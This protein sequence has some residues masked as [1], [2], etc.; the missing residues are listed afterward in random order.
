MA[1]K[2]S[3]SVTISHLIDIL[4]I[5]RYYM[6]QSSTSAA[7]TKPTTNPP[8]IGKNLIPYPYYNISNTRTSNGVTLTV[9]DDG[10]LT[11][12]GT[13][14][15]GHAYFTITSK[16]RL[17]AGN[18]YTLSG[19]PSGKS[20]ST[21]CL[22]I[23]SVAYDQS[24]S[25]TASFTLA[26]EKEGSLLSV[27]L[28]VYAGTTVNNLVF[29]PQVEIGNVA[30]EYEKP[31]SPNWVVTEPA[32]TAG[33]TNTLYF[34][35]VTTF[36]N[37]TFKCS[38]VS[39]S[40]SYEAAKEAYNKAASVESRVINA[41]T[42]I[43]SNKDAISLR[44]T[45]TE[46][47]NSRNG[48]LLQNG[49]GEYCDNTNYSGQYTRG[50][51]P[52]GA[53]G[54]FTQGGIFQEYI[55]FNK[56]VTYDYE[57]YVRRQPSAAASTTGYFSLI[58]YDVDKNIIFYRYVLTSNKNLF[59]LSQSLNPGDTVAHFT[60]LSE[61]KTDGT[62]NKNFLI[63]GYSDSTGYVYPD[64][65]YSRYCHYNIYSDPSS[66]N[67]TDNTITLSQPWTGSAYSAGTC[68]GQSYDGDT[69]IYLGDRSNHATEWTRQAG[70][71]DAGVVTPNWRMSHERLE[72]ARYIRIGFNVGASN[73]INYSKIY[74]GIHTVDQDARK[75]LDA[76]VGDLQQIKQK[77]T[78]YVDKDE[79]N[80]YRESTESRFD[81][82]SDNIAMN[83]SKTMEMI[84]SVDGDLKSRFNKLSKYI[85][86]SVDGIEIGDETNKLKLILDNDAIRFV[87]GSSTIGWWDGENFHTGNIMVRTRE[88]AQ[89]GQFAYVPRSDGSLMFLKVGPALG[90]P[91]YVNFKNADFFSYSTTPLGSTDGVIVKNEKSASMTI[92]AADG[93]GYVYVDPYVEIPQETDE[94]VWRTYRITYTVTNAYLSCYKPNGQTISGI[95]QSNTNGTYTVDVKGVASLRFHKIYD[96]A[97]TNFKVS[98]VK[99]EEVG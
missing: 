94:T 65:V 64:G 2:A 59:Y 73:L 95:S 99:I 82:F 37:G 4:S 88:R 7:P 48:N 29:K 1:V 79:Y 42:E 26:Q 75:N 18:R 24:E 33:S 41:E 72:I 98:N 80:K 78:D 43:R 9:N 34:V 47:V 28:A 52:D 36:T 5:T 39:Q 67:K 45:K 49:Y 32:Y 19:S 68:I 76:A 87:N 70:M 15:A 51:C 8:S 17:P 71:F 58:P 90:Y 61:W 21:Y 66:V 31:A 83:F 92:T 16:L 23:P 60:D 57:Y 63:F 55:P 81:V 84:G 6:L 89:F 10:T 3:A 62:Y 13:A 27:G 54:Y 56:N 69:Y 11:A 74:I 30:T 91:T 44:A 40:S 86:F 20:N 46:V 12:N 38:N 53:Y 14:G 96:Y 93:I 35:D 85:R 25:R 50:D 97:V 77:M 22:Y